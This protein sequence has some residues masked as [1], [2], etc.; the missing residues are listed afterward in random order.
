MRGWLT[1]KF[2]S[3]LTIS[4][5]KQYTFLSYSG[6]P[7]KVWWVNVAGFLQTQLKL[8]NLSSQCAAF[9]CCRNMPGTKQRINYCCLPYVD[10]KG[11]QNVPEFCEA[12]SCF[13]FGREIR[14][15]ITSKEEFNTERQ[16]VHDKVFCFL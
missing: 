16:L 8:W 6:G 4:T 3:E 1:K 14:M 2:K 10:P 7:S 13:T 5:W 11:S 12:W 15:V 9:H